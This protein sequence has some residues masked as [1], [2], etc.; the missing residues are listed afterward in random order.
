MSHQTPKTNFIPLLPVEIHSQ[1]K[2]ASPLINKMTQQGSEPR[3]ETAPSSGHQDRNQTSPGLSHGIVGQ[4]KYDYPS[5]KATVLFSQ[6]SEH[7]TTMMAEDKTSGMTTE[8][9]ELLKTSSWSL[10]HAREYQKHAWHSSVLGME[11]K[12]KDEWGFSSAS[13]SRSHTP[14]P[15]C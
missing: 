8:V 13:V 11:A 12:V 6:S 3:T 15:V 5:P 1:T 10:P 4:G 2:K 7:P 9:N 14:K